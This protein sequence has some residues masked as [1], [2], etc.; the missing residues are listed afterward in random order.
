MLNS[1]LLISTY[2]WPQALEVCLLS[3][4]KQSVQPD[5]VIICDDGSRPETTALIDSMR[6][7]FTVPVIHIWQPDEGF[8]LSRIRN[9]GI[10]TAKGDYII[11]VDG[12]LI[13]HRHFIKDHLTFRKKGFFTTGSRMLLSAHT[14]ENILKATSTDIKGHSKGNKNYLNSRRVPILHNFF[15]LRY[16]NKGR[17]KYYVKG[18]NMAFWKEDLLRVNGYNEDFSGWGREDSELAIR[19]MNAGVGKRFLKFGGVCYHM[20]HKEA[21]KALEDRNIKMMEE[22]IYN[23]VCRSSRGLDQYIKA[24]SDLP[25]VA[26]PPSVANVTNNQERSKSEI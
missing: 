25:T 13:L 23:K 20:F 8:Q 26:F 17:H 6:E 1:S 15:S 12:D 16:K 5:E 19:L 2:N 14:T 7:I 18:C 10:S 21:S 22:A 4:A 9:K 11:Q 24:K 3:V